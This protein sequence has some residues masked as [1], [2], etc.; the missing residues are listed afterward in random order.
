MIFEISFLVFKWRLAFA[1]RYPNL[2]SYSPFGPRQVCFFFSLKTVRLLRL[3]VLIV[4]FV[5]Y[6]LSP[7]SC[8]P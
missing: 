5:D 6:Y 7:V 2:T 8:N 3:T 4:N 1:R